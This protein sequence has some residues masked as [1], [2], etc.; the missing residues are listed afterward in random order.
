[1]S[2]LTVVR[3]QAELDAAIESRNPLI[4]IDSPPERYLT[5]MDTGSSRVEAWG[6]SRV[7]AR[8]SS[9]VVA[10]ESSSVE[11]WKSSSVEASRYVAVQR[12]PNRHGQKYP[13]VTGG[14]II[15]LPGGLHFSPSVAATHSYVNPSRYLLCE[16]DAAT[17]VCLGDKIKSESCRV[18]YEVDRHGDRIVADASEAAR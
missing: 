9:R 17:V 6:S 2:A 4:H 13:T 8:E 15:D 14:V 5:V 7:E 16:V 3:T 1:M 11:A 18:L 12:H 10:R